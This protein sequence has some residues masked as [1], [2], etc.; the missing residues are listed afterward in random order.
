[1]T[2]EDIADRLFM[3]TWWGAQATQWQSFQCCAEDSSHSVT[4]IVLVRM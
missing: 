3:D 2:E 1:M 4:A